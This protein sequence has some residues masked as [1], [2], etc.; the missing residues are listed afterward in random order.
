MRIFAL[1]TQRTLQGNSLSLA[2]VYS[3]NVV[4]VV[5][6]MWLHDPKR[7]PSARQVV[8]RLEVIMEEL[9]I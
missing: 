6:D 1:V 2:D 7:R 5:E 3:N 9:E 8:A 4:Q